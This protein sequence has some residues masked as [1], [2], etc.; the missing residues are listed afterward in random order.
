[1]DMRTKPV[2]IRK[3]DLLLCK[4]SISSRLNI[5]L[6]VGIVPEIFSIVFNVFA[7]QVHDSDISGFILCYQQQSDSHWEP[8]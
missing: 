5:P 3:I 1:M 7:W 6:V 8:E 2:K 4:W